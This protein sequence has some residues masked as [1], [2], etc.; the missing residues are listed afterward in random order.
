[1]VGIRSDVPLWNADLESLPR[2]SP[3]DAAPALQTRFAACVGQHE[4][5]FD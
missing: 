1:M 5:S 4:M 3:G 2:M